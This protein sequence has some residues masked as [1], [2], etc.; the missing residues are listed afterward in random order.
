MI[1]FSTRSFL[2]LA[3]VFIIANYSVA[4]VTTSRI[5]GV[6]LDENQ[7]GLPGANIIAVHG[8]TGISYGTTS[9]LDGRYNLPNLKVGG[10]YTL[11]VSFVGYKDRK[12]ENVF[13][14]LGETFSADFVMR[15]ESTE[16]EEIVVQAQKGE[17]DSERTGAETTVDNERLMKMP[18]IRRSA[19]DIYRLSP[20][21][22]GDSFGGRNDQYNNFSLDG[23]IF[24]NPFKPPFPSRN[25][26][27]MPQLN[28]SRAF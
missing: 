17:F 12:L 3:A 24:N 20:Q 7:E 26:F 25:V 10:P 14:V 5:S 27:I 6:V 2:L 1:Q 9:R 16:L 21:S 28:F 4:Q 22:S 15:P 13:L 19:S 18:T 11:N 23:S 8:P